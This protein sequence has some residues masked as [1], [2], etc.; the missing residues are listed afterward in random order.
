MGFDTIYWIFIA[1]NRL[2]DK[3]HMSRAETYS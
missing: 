2:L 1:T 3:F